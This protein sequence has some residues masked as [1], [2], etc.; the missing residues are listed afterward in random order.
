[1]K[2]QDYK[3][4]QDLLISKDKLEILYRI[5][6]FPYPRIF[7]PLKKL[8]FFC[9]NIEICFVSFDEQTQKELK[10]AI[11]QVISKRLEEI[12]EEIENI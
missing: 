9:D 1:M 11:K 6:S 2:I 3:K 4:V 5:F 12:E 10:A 7:V 8:L